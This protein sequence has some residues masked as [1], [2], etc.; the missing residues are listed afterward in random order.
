MIPKLK[1]DVVYFP[2]RDGVYLRNKQDSS[3]LKGKEVSKLLDIILPQLDGHKTLEEITQALSPQ[4]RVTITKL[5]KLLVEKGFVKDL[6]YDHPHELTMLEQKTYA[7]EIAFIDTFTDSAAYKFERY[8]HCNLLLI[9][10]GLTLTALVHAQLHSGL[11]QVN[12]MVTDECLTDHQRH[13]DY[14]TLYQAKGCQQ[15]IHEVKNID[16]NNEEAVR[17]SIQS[18]DA[19]LAISDKPMLARAALLNRICVDQQKP[20]MQAV[21]VEDKAWV[22]P[23]VQPGKPHCWECAWHRLQANL[24]TMTDITNLA[25]YDLQDWPASAVSTNV[26]ATTA[27][28]VAN[29]ASF[30]V[31]KYLTGAGSLETDEY[32]IKIDLE[33]LQNERHKFLP[34]PLCASHH[35]EPLSFAG[36]KQTLYSLIEGPT[37]D[38]E[39]FS[40]SSVQL[41]ESDLGIFSGLDERDFTQLPLNVSEIT[42]S[43]PLSSV[44]S[45]AVKVVGVGTNFAMPRLRATQH[46]CEIYATRCIDTQ[47]FIT[48]TQIQAYQ[49]KGMAIAIHTKKQVQTPEPDE[50]YAWVYELIA[51]KISV[52]PAIVAFPSLENEK[53]NTFKDMQGVAS[54]MSWAEAVSRA[55][56]AHC[57]EQ[58]IEQIASTQQAFPVLDLTALSLSDVSQRYYQMAKM[59]DSD[60]VAY[61]VTG[62][63]KIPT[64]A[65]CDGETT[66]AYTSHIDP[67]A[68]IQEGLEQI[69][70]YKQAQINHEPDYAPRSVP[71]IPLELKGK[72]IFTPSS[73]QLSSWTTYQTRLIEMLKQWYETLFVVPLDHDPAL[74]NTLPYIVRVIA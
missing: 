43:N 51:E 59:M 16:W 50:R 20:F 48:G 58:T 1:N 47:R 10:S 2:S 67:M 42:L 29:I 62:K 70:Q 68:A 34:H 73:L 35:R 27:A 14:A 40:R 54:G 37:L 66:V 57:K 26:A 60:V 15:D 19:V 69:V 61:D 22:G 8:R 6:T 44:S 72:V 3:V 71:Q 64:F 13:T 74:S 18:Y 36:F 21:L 56:L 41:I 5:L 24:S 25:L 11:R 45:A 55:L 28:V 33:T 7:A 65:F 52:L 17:Q 23:L 49:N 53:K 39:T 12:I 38:P 63:L 9:G 46:A 32:L 31:F 4:M 30:E